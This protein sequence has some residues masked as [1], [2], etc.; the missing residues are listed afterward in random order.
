MAIQF[1]YFSLSAGIFRLY[2]YSLIVLY[3]YIPYNTVLF[4]CR[5]RMLLF[6]NGNRNTRYVWPSTCEINIEL[7]L[8]SVTVIQYSYNIITYCI[9][10]VAYCI[11]IVWYKS[12]SRR[13]TFLFTKVMTGVINNSPCL[14][15]I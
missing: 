4:Y 11:V 6:T 1:S 2:S 5:Y 9:H 14:V 8:L 12:K 13:F 15:K 10:I 7:I 3:S